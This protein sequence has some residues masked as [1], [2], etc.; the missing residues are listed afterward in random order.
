MLRFVSG[1]RSARQLAT[2]LLDRRSLGMHCA[3]SSSTGVCAPR[4]INQTSTCLLSARLN[5][6]VAAFVLMLQASFNHLAL[7]LLQSNGSTSNHTVAPF[8][9]GQW[10]GL[11]IWA[12]IVLGGALCIIFLAMVLCC[13]CCNLSFND[14]AIDAG[15][16]RSSTDAAR[17]PLLSKWNDGDDQIIGRPERDIRHFVA[18]YP[19]PSR[20]TTVQSGSADSSSSM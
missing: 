14:T 6:S 18:S 19:L 13:F 15:E 2:N 16:K 1:G 10:E 7:G 5:R 3:F 4:A 17:V 8:L 9:L 12:W 11:P 20:N